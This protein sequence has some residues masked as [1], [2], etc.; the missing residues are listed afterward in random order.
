MLEPS[1]P[2]QQ[3]R[4]VSRSTHKNSVPSSSSDE[5][6]CSCC[7]KVAATSQNLRVQITLDQPRKAPP[8]PAATALLPYT[9]AMELC[10]V[11]I[12]A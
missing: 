1:Q 7:S 10:R 6:C 2:A 5:T 3:H 4:A 12:T 11:L 9:A 8:W